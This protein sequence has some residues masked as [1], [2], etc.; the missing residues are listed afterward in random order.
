MPSPVGVVLLAKGLPLGT[1][2]VAV[3]KKVTEPAASNA[4]ILK[5]SIRLKINTINTL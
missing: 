2:L 3:E 5:A 1:R 4:D